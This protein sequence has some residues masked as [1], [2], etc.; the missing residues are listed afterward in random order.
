MLSTS[1]SEIFTHRL[2][3]FALQRQERVVMESDHSKMNFLS[4]FQLAWAMDLLRRLAESVLTERFALAGLALARVLG[5]N[6]D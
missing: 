3:S 1:V 6:K 2:H 4:N 5:N